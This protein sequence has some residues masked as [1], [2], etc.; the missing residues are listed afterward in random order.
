M[1]S[2]DELHTIKHWQSLGETPLKT[3][4]KKLSTLTKE[5][6]KKETNLKR[7]YLGQ[8][9]PNIYFTLREMDVAI[10]LIK[11]HTYQQ[12]A[13]ILT[14]SARTIEYYTKQIRLKL[15]CEKKSE[16]IQ[17]LRTME[18]IQNYDSL[19]QKNT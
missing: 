4:P 9:Y 17:L 12:I 14:L 11:N 18:V 7:Y 1:T 3:H 10:L 5:N 15:R 6:Q 16:S 2:N 13:N 19:K 8:N